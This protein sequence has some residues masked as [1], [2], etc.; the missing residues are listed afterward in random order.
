MWNKY[1]GSIIRHSQPIP[2]MYK[3][4]EN[5]D[6]FIPFHLKVSFYSY[7]VCILHANMHK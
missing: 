1:G 6:I 5:D 7:S 4:S 3:I 2:T